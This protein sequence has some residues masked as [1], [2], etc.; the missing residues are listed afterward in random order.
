MRGR[1]EKFR[2]YM[3]SLDGAA[4][5]AN[6][7][8]QGFYVEQ[9]GSVAARI[10]ARLEL[11]PASSHLIVGGIGTGKTTQLLVAKQRWTEEDP[12]R[13]GLYVD[14]SK[15]QDL[16]RLKAGSLMAL[17]GL[18]LS[19]QIEH[20]ASDK[21]RKSFK[22]WAH[23]SWVSSEWD[24][25]PP[26]EYY[27]EPGVITPPQSKL[28]DTLANKQAELREF[29]DAA[30]HASRE[31]EIVIFIDS[32]DRMSSEHLDGFRL[33]AEQDIAALTAIGIGLVLVGP[34]RAIYGLERV[35]ADSF[36]YLYRQPAFNVSQDSREHAFVMDIVRRRVSAEMLPDAQCDKLVTLSGGVL[37]DLMRLAHQAGEE[38]YMSGAEQIEDIHVIRAADSFGRSLMIGLS[39]ED[40]DK[41]QQIHQSG[42]FIE[43]SERDLALLVT[44]RILDYQ[45]VS[46]VRYAIHPTLIPLMTQD[47]PADSK[48]G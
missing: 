24:G 32:L 12:S 17:V 4:D 36:H 46:G 29:V 22:E 25:V 33:L 2:A 16:S 21:I 27:F 34:L 47:R 18:V 7:L 8:A 19:E 37:R 11:K 35:V 40:I 1:K 44:R 13:I 14:L 28:D 15:Y 31:R 9:A 30:L 45:T 26:D 41:L 38:A 3:A 10:A 48:N 39:S 42:R 5:P 23:G 20:P 43:T 6:A